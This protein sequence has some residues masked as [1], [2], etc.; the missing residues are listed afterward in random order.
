MYDN[1]EVTTSILTRNANLEQ[2]R[3]SWSPHFLSSYDSLFCPGK[4]FLFAC[5]GHQIL[6]TQLVMAL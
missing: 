2:I 6:D 1:D 4:N 5:F 3:E